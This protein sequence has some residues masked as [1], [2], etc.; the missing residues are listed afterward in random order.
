MTATDGRCPV[1]HEPFDDHKLAPLNGLL[2]KPT[3]RPA[4]DRK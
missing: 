3:C 1:C 2:M 4:K